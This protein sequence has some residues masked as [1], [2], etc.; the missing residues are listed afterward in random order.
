M[1]APLRQREGAPKRFGERRIG[2]HEP[3]AELQ[4][5]LPARAERIA[6]V[7]ACL[8]SLGEAL[9]LEQ[10]TIEDIALAV[11]EACTNVVLHAYPARCGGPLFLQLVAS[12]GPERDEVTIDVRVADNGAGIAAGAETAVPTARGG[13]GVGMQVMKTLAR[14]VRVRR[15][16]NGTTEVELR[17]QARGLGL[18]QVAR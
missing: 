11:T 3:L 10:R 1:R 5:R 15:D 6:Y 9:A 13:L 12:R 8:R 16:P 7:R 18:C 4:L 2:E 17:F 14:R